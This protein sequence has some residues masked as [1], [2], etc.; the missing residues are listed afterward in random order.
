MPTEFDADIPDAQLALRARCVH[1]TGSFTPFPS[2]AL[3][4]SIARRFEAQAARRPDR[5]ALKTR[6]ARAHLRELDAVANRIARAIAAHPGAAGDPVALMFDPGPLAIAAM[7]A[8]LKAGR[9]YVPLDPSYPLARL[10]YIVRDATASLRAD[11]VVA[12]RAGPDAGGRCGAD[13]G[14]GVPRPGSGRSVAGRSGP[15]GAGARSSIR[16]APPDSRRASCTTTATCS[17]T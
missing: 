16:P 10:D 11:R 2:A 1:P 4:T 3:E 12:C 8:A 6:R 9:P 7:L 14:R 13:R 17:T 15:A 5:L